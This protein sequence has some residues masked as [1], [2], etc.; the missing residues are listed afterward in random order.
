MATTRDL[1]DATLEWSLADVKKWLDGLI[2]GEA[3][4]G[5]A[6]NWDVFAFTIAARARR[7]QSPDWAYIA[8]RVYEALARNPPSGADAHTY[9]LSEM[10]LRA[11]L[12]SELG[13]R[14]GDP[15]LDSEPIVA[16]IQRLTTISL[17]EASRWLALVEEDFRAVPVEKLR[18][19]RRIKHG[20]NT[21]AH[22][23][24]QTKAEQKH[25]ELTPWLQLR[26]RLP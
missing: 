6:F 19:L 7:E 22:A 11:G 23:L 25:P 24:P 4:E 15:V 18:V 2:I 3:V 26:T 12:I 13:E 21:L 17:E 5:D 10:N 1:L 9:K 8:L 20:L 16:W 14:E